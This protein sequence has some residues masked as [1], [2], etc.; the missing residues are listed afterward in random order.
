MSKIKESIC[1]MGLTVFTQ[2][3]SD[4]LYKF[5]ILPKIIQRHYLWDFIFLV[6]NFLFFIIDKKVPKMTFFSY[7]NL[8]KSIC[9][10]YQIKVIIF[11][12][13]KSYKIPSKSYLTII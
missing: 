1:A 2:I 10:V 12:L 8:K 11:I 13:S 3:C 7:Q 6:K 9:I 5:W 4:K